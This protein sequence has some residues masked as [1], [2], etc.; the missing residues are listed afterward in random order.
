MTNH[1]LA[2]RIAATILADVTDRR[3]WKQEWEYRFPPEVKEVIWETWMEEIE[4]VLDGG[5]LSLAAASILE[6]P[7]VGDLLDGFPDD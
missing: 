4:G 5:P 6:L 7:T 1:D 2:R 3:G